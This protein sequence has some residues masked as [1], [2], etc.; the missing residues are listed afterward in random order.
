MCG[1]KACDMQMLSAYLCMPCVQV[2]R[3][4]CSLV[5]HAM[6]V[7]D[8]WF[9]QAVFRILSNVS[10][11]PVKAECLYATP[12]GADM[13]VGHMRVEPQEAGVG[14][15]EAGQILLAEEST[16]AEDWGAEAGVTVSEAGVS[17]TEAGVVLVVAVPMNM[18]GV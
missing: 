14:E 2:S 5:H 10:A 16:W 1:Q 12:A 9:M 13:G 4:D 8:E 7:A 18:A 11:V 17:T 3:A 6:C 15:S